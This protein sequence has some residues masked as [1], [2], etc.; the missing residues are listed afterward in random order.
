MPPVEPIR[1]PITEFVD[2]PKKVTQPWDFDAPGVRPIPEP[3][4]PPCS[5]GVVARPKP[6][7]WCC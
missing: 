3:Y 4:N 6:N 1:P 5:Q 2:I 7:G